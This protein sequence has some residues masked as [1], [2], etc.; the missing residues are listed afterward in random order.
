MNDMEIREQV[1]EL[2][3]EVCR[4]CKDFVEGCVDQDSCEA[5]QAEIERMN[6]LDL[7]Q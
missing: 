3:M 4:Q 6:K 2:A 5:Y 7:R 1:E